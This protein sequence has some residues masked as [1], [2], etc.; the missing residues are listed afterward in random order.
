MSLTAGMLLAAQEPGPPVGTG[1]RWHGVSDRLSG[2]LRGVSAAGRSA[3]ER[4]ISAAFDRILDVDLGGI[5]VGGWRTYRSLLEAARAT[6]DDPLR[7][8]TVALATHEI[9]VAHHP[10]IE[11]VVNEAVLARVQCDL[12]IALEVSGVIAVVSRAH[13]VALQGGG[14]TAAVTLGCE[15]HQIA[16]VRVAELDP[17]LMVSLGGGIALLQED[18]R[19]TPA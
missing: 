9:T 6:R 12:G 18:R 10:C 17:A 8:E 15:G 13:L 16:S 11:I 19:P 5:L 4:E 1:S 3:V 7:T 2:P 14:V